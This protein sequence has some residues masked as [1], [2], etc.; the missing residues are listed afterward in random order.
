VSQVVQSNSATSQEAAAAS[1]EL[2]GQAENLLKPDR[3][4]PAAQRSLIL[5]TRKRLFNAMGRTA[6][7]YNPVGFPGGC[8]RLHLT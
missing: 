8:S 1:E 3:P 5:K 2:T 4:F 7:A 6:Q